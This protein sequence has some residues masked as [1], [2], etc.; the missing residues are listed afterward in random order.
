LNAEANCHE[1]DPGRKNRCCKRSEPYADHIDPYMSITMMPANEALWSISALT[2]APC[3]RIFQFQFGAWRG[4]GLPTRKYGKKKL[5]KR[6]KIA[7]LAAGSYYGRE[8]LTELMI[9]P[10][11]R[12]S[13]LALL[14]LGAF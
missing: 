1:A 14:F 8:A 2:I 9:W 6:R 13:S 11:A 12:K 5:L 3:W 4:A 7:I 10:T